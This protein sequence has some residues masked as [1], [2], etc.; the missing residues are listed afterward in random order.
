MVSIGDFSK[1]LCGGIHLENSSQIETFEITSEE[2]VSSGTRRIAAVTGQKAKEN[3]LRTQMIAD[4]VARM[5]QVPI[6]EISNGVIQLS[7]RVKMLKKQISSGNTG[8]SLEDIEQGTTPKS[9]SPTYFEVRQ[10]V[11]RTAMALNVK[12]EDVTA[13]VKAMLQDVEEL[14]KQVA[15]M[16][17]AEKV[18]ADTLI[19]SSE[20]MGDVKVIVQELVGSNKNI[21]RSLIDQVRKKTGPVAIFLATA[22]GSD[23]VVLVAGVSK[24]LVGKG[25]NAGKWVGEVAPVVGGRGGGRADL[26]EAGGKQPENIKPALMAASE[27]IKSVAAV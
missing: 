18:D 14:K 17:S 11:R 10:E 16:E 7:S 21:M 1:E 13:R 20:L 4:D 27:F 2:S 26:A 15:T 24:E 22:A 9:D 5:L 25:F 19:G 12:V 3:Q 8:K 6:A 23:K